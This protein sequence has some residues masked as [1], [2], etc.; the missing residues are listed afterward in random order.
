MSYYLEGIHSSDRV[1]YLDQHNYSEAIAFYKRGIETDPSCMSNYW[2][3]CLA[4]LLQ[5]EESEAKATWLS[6]IEQADDIDKISTWTLEMVELLMAE[7]IKREAISDLEFAQKMHG[8]AAIA[9]GEAWKKVKG[10]KFTT[11]WFI[12]NLPIWERYLIHLANQP[13]INVLEI[14]SWEGMSACWL[15][16]NIL[17]HESS[18][19]TCIDTFEGSVEHKFEYD[20]NYI[21]S[22]AERFDFNISQTNASEKVIKIIGD[23]QDVMRSLP[24]NNYDILYI[25]GSHLASDVLTDAVLGWRLVKVGGIIIFDDYDFQFDDSLNAGEDTKV[26]IDAFLKVFYKKVNIIYQAHQVIVEKTLD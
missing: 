19:I 7:A 9:R 15:L 26:G 24:F 23:S 11:D 17:T 14:G 6:V 18:R 3:I 20:D 4:L 21:K 12:D 25:D 8:Y 5:G 22:V 2:H 16:D 10:Y 13:K 1:K